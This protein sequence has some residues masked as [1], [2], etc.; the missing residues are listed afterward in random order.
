[1]PAAGTLAA[2]LFDWG[3]TLTPWHDVDL[4]AQWHAYAAAYDPARADQLAGA[5]HD[6][7]L[8]AWQRATEHHRSGTFDDL[9]RA[10]GIDPR[11]ARHE[12]ALAAYLDF[13]APHTYVDPEARALLAALRER[14]LRVGVLSNTY[15]PRRHHEAVFERDGILPLID[16]AVYSSEIPWTKPH[17]EAFRTALRAVGCT[18]PAAA[19]FVGDRPYDDISGAAAVGM[20]TIF[21]PHSAVPAYDVRP[22]A[23]VSRLGEVL[24]IVDAWRGPR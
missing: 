22:D 1:M 23:T 21:V 19:A 12:R 10:A 3:G 4:Y 13:W 8:A 20:R 2:V 14:G 24:A 6:A 5:L 18:D 15:W 17:P 11:G 16:A 7:E 9:L